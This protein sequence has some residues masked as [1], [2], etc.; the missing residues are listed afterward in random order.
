[1]NI[2]VSLRYYD[3]GTNDVWSIRQY[4]TNYYM[5]MAKKFNIGICAI[6]SDNDFE[7]IC[8]RCD[9]LIIPGS[10]TI[11]NPKYYGA[12]PEE[13]PFDEYALDQKLM[14]YFTDHKKP[15]LGL[16]GGHQALNI[17][18]GGTIKMIDNGVSHNDTSHNI[19]IKKG[20]F[21]YDVFQSESA[22]INSYHCYEI[23]K[24]APALSVVATSPDGII[25]A[26]E[27]KEKRMFAT[28]WHPE[29]TLTEENHIEHKFFENFFKCCKEK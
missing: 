19:D 7:V 15:I 17:F 27:N 9:G 26:V 4:I 2:A 12:T 24:L 6:M 16:C 3:T 20:S 8:E 1:M 11:I 18:L 21:V 25:E 14:K 28:Q 10:S 13:P 29:L 23:D 5:L 22:H